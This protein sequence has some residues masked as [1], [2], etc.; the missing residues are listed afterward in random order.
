M[1]RLK[2]SMLVFGLVAREVFYPLYP[3]AFQQPF[4]GTV[5]RACAQLYP[6]L[7]EALHVFHDGVAVPGSGSQADQDY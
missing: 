4:E 2:S 7:A 1:K 6:S 3:T 5:E